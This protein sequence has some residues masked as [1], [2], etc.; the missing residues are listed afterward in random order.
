MS[1]PNFDLIRRLFHEAVAAGCHGWN[2]VLRDRG[3]VSSREMLEVRRLL[4]NH[5]P[6]EPLLAD[7]G[8]TSSA[9]QD[10]SD[11]ATRDHQPSSGMSL[12]TDTGF[13]LLQRRSRIW[14]GVRP[15]LVRSS[16]VFLI[17]LLLASGAAWWVCTELA[18]KWPNNCVQ[19]R[20]LTFRFM[21]V[22]S[23]HVW[24]ANGVSW[25]HGDGIRKSL[26]VSCSLVRLHRLTVDLQRPSLRALQQAN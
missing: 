20:R 16:L 2:S 13:G 12:A 24:R 10:N 4:Q 11:S 26:T 6:E 1:L 18:G 21:S 23:E 7:D 5:N 15:E 3:D 17:L 22:P 9:A 25:N 8:G 14:S 19:G